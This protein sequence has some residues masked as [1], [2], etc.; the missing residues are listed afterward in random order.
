MPRAL[1][2]RSIPAKE[3]L[4][5]RTQYFSP[6][7][8]WA[9]A[10]GR[11][12]LP[13]VYDQFGKPEIVSTAFIRHR[14]KLSPSPLDKEMRSGPVDEILKDDVFGPLSAPDVEVRLRGI[15][16]SCCRVQPQFVPP[17][18]SETYACPSTGIDCSAAGQCFDNHTSF[19]VEYDRIGEAEEGMESIVFYFIHHRSFRPFSLGKPRQRSNSRLRPCDRSLSKIGGCQHGS[20]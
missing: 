17:G 19:T 7:F 14:K 15:L 12:Y 10:G 6:S 4:S 1:L 20:F 3:A 9:A 11:V 16:R 13:A 2:W 5:P 8:S 18:N